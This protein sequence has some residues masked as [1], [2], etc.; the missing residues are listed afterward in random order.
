VTPIVA[1]VGCTGA[2]RT[3]RASAIVSGVTRSTRVAI[4]CEVVITTAG[5]TL[6]A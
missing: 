1:V 3:G 6:T 2:A 4:G 5:T